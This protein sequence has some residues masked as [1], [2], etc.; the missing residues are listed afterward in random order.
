MMKKVLI[1]CM[2]IAASVVASV[3]V[4][5][6]DVPEIAPAAG[7]AAPAADDTTTGNKADEAVTPGDKA[8]L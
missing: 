3:D 7:K 1:P 5:V 2:L 6:P 4:P 8:D